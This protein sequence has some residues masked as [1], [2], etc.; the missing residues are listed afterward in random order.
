MPINKLGQPC[1][2]CSM[3]LHKNN[4]AYD[5]KLY[6]QKYC[7]ICYKLNN[8]IYRARYKAKNKEAFTR[9]NKHYGLMKLYGISITTWDKILKSQ[10][11]VCAICKIH[12]TDNNPLVMDHSHKTNINRGIICKKCNFALGLLNDNENIIWNILEYLKKYEWEKIA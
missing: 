3:I 4:A 2:R 12:G 11:N 6:L 5:G 10:N 8:K 1:A 7:N 9:S